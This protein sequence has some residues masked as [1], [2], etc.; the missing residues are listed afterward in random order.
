[1]EAAA[2]VRARV[3]HA[4][5]ADEEQAV[6]G[7]LDA[8]ATNVEAR[9]RRAEVPVIA[10]VRGVTAACSSRI[11]HREPASRSN[12]ERRRVA[13]RWRTDARASAAVAEIV[14]VQDEVQ[15]V[16]VVVAAVHPVVD[17]IPQALNVAVLNT[18]AVGRAGVLHCAGVVRHTVRRAHILHTAVVAAAVADFRLRVPVGKLY[19][20]E[21]PDGEPHGEIHLPEVRAEG[22][23]AASGGA[24]G[25]VV[26]R[27][28]AGFTLVVAGAVIP[29]DV[30]D[31][32]FAVSVAPVHV[33]GG[34]REAC[35]RLVG[36][37]DFDA[38]AALSELV[39]ELRN[40]DHRVTG[41]S[42][43]CHSCPRLQ[44]VKRR[45]VTARAGHIRNRVNK[46]GGFI[47][48][49]P[50]GGACA[51]PARAV[52]VHEIYL[53]PA[54]LIRR[55]GVVCACGY[56]YRD[57]GRTGGF[58]CDSDFVPGNADCG[59]PGAAG[60]GRNRAVACTGY[61]DRPGLRGVVQ[62]H[63]GRVKA[64]GACRLSNRPVH[65]L[66]GRSPVSPLVVRPRRED[67]AVGSRIGSGVRAADGHF[68]GVVV[69]PCRRLRGACVG[70]AAA[71][72][73]RC[74][75]RPVDS[76]LDGLGSLRII[77]PLKPGL[78]RERR[79]ISTGI[80]GLRC[81]AEGELAFIVI[82]PRRGLLVARKG[83]RPAGGRH[84]IDCVREVCDGLGCGFRKLLCVLRKR[85]DRF[86]LRGAHAGDI[87]RSIRHECFLL[88]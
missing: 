57:G 58:T 24:S 86:Q 55:G 29:A 9:V 33:C 47:G 27:R 75:G 61:S 32:P 10:R 62:R 1:M 59:N 66:C 11:E 21:Q 51:V 81:T 6:A 14:G 26:L 52:D 64:K 80:R 49:R 73:G 4:V 87:Y 68:A 25:D 63:I 17:I 3:R 46:A 15:P 34:N 5:V 13:A 12:I 43:L 54:S 44:I 8:V 82:Q 7:A 50:F 37:L 18:Y 41:A 56:L 40:N 38:A 65:R 35:G 30:N 16:A 70:Q 23:D 78:R 69:C 53:N 84:N 79:L 48:S 77:R 60:D 31:I 19:D 74:D 83:E 85:P 20:I 36:D 76:P 22:V 71:R 42:G 2:D 45:A 88:F 28:H 67:C 72:R 39:P